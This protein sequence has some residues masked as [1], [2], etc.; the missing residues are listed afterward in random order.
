M[1][2]N[3]SKFY[4][5]KYL[6]GGQE[7]SEIFYLPNER[8][9]RKELARRNLMAMSIEEN[10]V[11]WYEQEI[12]SSTYKFKFL[13]AIGFHV[14][15]GMSPGRALK[16]VI[17]GEDNKSIRATLERAQEVLSRGG[18]FAEALQ[19]I[20][21]YSNSVIALLLAGEKT[22]TLGNSITT[23]IKFME[24][25]QSSAKAHKSA[26]TWFAIEFMMAFSGVI[27][28]QYTF[29]PWIQQQVMQNQNG[30]AELLRQLDVAFFLNGSL[31]YLAIALV[32]GVIGLAGAIMFGNSNLKQRAAKKLAKIPGMRSVFYDG[33]LYIH[34]FLLEKMLSKGAGFS[35][36]LESCIESSSLP[37]I[38][39]MWRDV[40]TKIKQGYSID[41]ALT[42]DGLL[43]KPEMI[44]IQAHQDMI[45]LEHVFKTIANE[46]KR[47]SIEGQKKV[48]MVGLFLS[49]GYSLLSVAIAIWAL[50]LQ[51]QGFNLSMG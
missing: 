50:S 38:E 34:F 6:V 37:D 51:S 18:S 1:S 7:R 2:D 8:S 9:V 21:F 3:G 4:K 12:I 15:S 49:I 25:T 16:T 48:V 23:A 43:T 41:Y 19:L 33:A 27:A 5:A 28:V 20:G 32:L 45:Q 26:M 22:G 44:E 40:Q 24:E 29:L 42:Q 13:R 39:H 17:E 10:V 36:G 35:S 47:N 14:Q 11:R 30:D 46:R 31:M